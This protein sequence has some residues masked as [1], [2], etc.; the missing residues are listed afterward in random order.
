MAFHGIQR[1]AEWCGNAIF[2]KIENVDVLQAKSPI[3]LAV[4][5]GSKFIEQ[6]TFDNSIFYLILSILI[7]FAMCSICL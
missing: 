5:S 4:K 6:F 3:K 1:I 7:T 2:G